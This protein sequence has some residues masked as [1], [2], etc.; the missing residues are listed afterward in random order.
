MNDLWDL[1]AP[2]YDTWMDPLERKWLAPVRRWLLAGARGRTL[3]VGVG[4]GVNLPFYPP[5]VELTG[6]DSSPQMLERARQR[7]HELGRE[8]D[9]RVANAD[10]IDD[11]DHTYD[12]LV[13]T[14]LLCS[15]DHEPQTLQEFARVLR[16]GGYLLLLDHVESSSPLIR[17]VQRVADWATTTWSGE[18]W[19]RRPLEHLQTAGFAVHQVR[20]SR[21]RLVEAVVAIK[22]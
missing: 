22:N 14:L 20:S 8:I 16:P 15:V 10:A 13:A 7:A 5:E 21:N 12:T 11:P 1:A 3:D 17:Q 19:G 18:R 9:L 6:V 2:T 4:T